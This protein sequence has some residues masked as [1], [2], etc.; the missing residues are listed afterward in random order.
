M[1]NLKEISAMMGVPLKRY[2]DIRAMGNALAVKLHTSVIATLGRD[3]M[4]ICDA[5]DGSVCHV[6]APKVRAVDVTGAGDVAT[7]ACALAIASGATLVE[8]AEFASH[9]GSISVT[10]LGTATVTPGEIRAFYRTTKK[11]LS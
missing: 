6:R 1:P 3:G 2:Q 5:Q 9:A 7:A 10:K 4:M 8:A 11:P